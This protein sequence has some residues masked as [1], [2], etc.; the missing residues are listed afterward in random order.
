MNRNKHIPQSTTIHCLLM[1]CIAALAGCKKEPLGD[2]PPASNSRTVIVYL[3]VDNNFRA[4]AA[5][6]IK[7]LTDNWDKTTDGNLLV[8]ADAG[9]T[10][11]LVHIYHTPQR[12]NVADTV[13]TYPSE[14]SAGAE[15][16]ARVLNSAKA[17]RPAASYGLVL[18]SHAT[19]WLPAEMSLPAPA[20]KSVITDTKAGETTN[21]MQLSDFALAIPYK[22]DFIVFDACFMGS[23]EVACE[24]NGKT[25][26][27]VA[28]PAEV[29]VPGFAYTTMMRHLFAPVA[30]LTAV[31]REFYEYYNGL[32][33]MWRSAT[34]SVIKMSELAAL[35]DAVKNIIQQSPPSG[36]LENIQTYGYG[37]QKIYFDLGDYMLKRSS[38]SPQA[39]ALMQE[40]RA[41][42]DRC[43]IYKACT[44]SYYSAG[45]SAMQPLN[46]FSGLSVYIPQSLYPVANEAYATLKWALATG[47]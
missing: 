19:G 31:A 47:N 28:S 34:V 15:T 14:N 24:L 22:L 46:K 13:E 38:V 41:S 2:T 45:T 1:L 3:G 36:K 7:Q 23:A 35:T 25:D 37:T 17:Y 26:Y 29:L 42:L 12:G 32:A 11:V 27:I 21:G 18:L 40:F 43:V 5:Q 10:P 30:D 44:P 20:L 6:K 9:P 4:E 8:Y 39:A 16:L 33:G